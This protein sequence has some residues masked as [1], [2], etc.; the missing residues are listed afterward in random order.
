MSS[1]TKTQSITMTE[2]VEYHVVHHIISDCL[3]V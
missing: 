3:G 1:D 2:D